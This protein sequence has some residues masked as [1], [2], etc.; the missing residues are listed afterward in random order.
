MTSSTLTDRYVAATLRTL[1]E[2]QRPDIEKELRASIADAVDDRI[3]RRGR[4]D[5][6]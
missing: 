6:R 4:P 5:L 1:P 2:K 3:E